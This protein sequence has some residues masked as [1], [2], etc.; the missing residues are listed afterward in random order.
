MS[1]FRLL[2]HTADIG[3]QVE[4]TDLASLFHEAGRGLQEIIGGQTPQTGQETARAIELRATDRA[5]LLVLWLQEWLFLFDTYGLV[6]VR[7]E[8]ETL[9]ETDLRATLY[10]TP[11]EQSGFGAEREVKAVTYHRLKLASTPRG[12]LA[13]VYFDL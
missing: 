2:E 7:D 5:D 11:V 8:I 1:P 10:C 4:S 6:I 12:W 13:E 3:L 9:T